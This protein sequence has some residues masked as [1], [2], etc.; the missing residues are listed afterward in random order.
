MSQARNYNRSLTKAQSNPIQRKIVDRYF[1]LKEE[2]SKLP[3]KEL[4]ALAKDVY[5]GKVKLSK[6]DKQALYDTYRP[7]LM[8]KAQE[9]FAN[10]MAEPKKE[11]TKNDN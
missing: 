4:D 8:Q 6:T 11:E 2:Y 7:Q 10:K 3:Y 9:E 5:E 1:R